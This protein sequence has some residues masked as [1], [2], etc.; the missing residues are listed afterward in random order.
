M[1]A[2]SLPFRLLSADYSK[3]NLS[4]QTFIICTD[5]EQGACPA[6]TRARES[7]AGREIAGYGMYSSQAI[8]CNARGDSALAKRLSGF[9]LTWLPLC[10]LQI[11]PWEHVLSS[12]SQLRLKHH[13]PE[14]QSDQRLDQ[15]AATRLPVP[16]MYL[17]CHRHRHAICPQR[18]RVICRSTSCSIKSTNLS[19]CVSG[20]PSLV[21][22]FHCEKKNPYQSLFSKR[23]P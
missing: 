18:P 8:W 9:T 1:S 4:N 16:R 2:F 15:R 7:N 5:S 13:R 12:S 23:T 19:P 11:G 14:D 20:R 22:C 21:F 3:N 17:R 6:S 10:G